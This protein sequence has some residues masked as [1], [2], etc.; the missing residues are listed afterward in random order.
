MQCSQARRCWPLFLLPILGCSNGRETPLNLAPTLLMPT[1]TGTIP[2]LELTIDKTL[3]TDFTM[4]AIDP[5]GD[6][7]T[8]TLVDVNAGANAA[9]L[10]LPSGP[11]ST[12]ELAIDVMVRRR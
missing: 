2:V 12:S 3:T 10:T 5:E 8:W 4:A 7:I 6:P 9:G 1:S 11:T